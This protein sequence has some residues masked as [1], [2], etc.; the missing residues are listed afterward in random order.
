MERITGPVSH[1]RRVV[2]KPTLCICEN[3]DADKLC[4][5]READKRICFRDMD[6]TIPILSKSEISSFYIAIFS[7]CADRF[8]SDLVENHEDRF[9]HNKAQLIL[10]HLDGLSTH[11]R[12][13]DRCSPFYLNS[14]HIISK[15]GN[16]CDL[17]RC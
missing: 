15:Y 7:G 14:I 11:A 8:V 3:K 16:H 4:G 13:G 2:R 17:T 1:L 5:N 6:S 12:L 10:P 9:S